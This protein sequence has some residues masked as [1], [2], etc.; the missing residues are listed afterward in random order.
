VLPH[1]YRGITLGLLLV[2]AS[3]VVAHEPPW[4]DLS[5]P[6]VI[7]LEGSFANDRKEAAANGADAVSMR[8]RGRDR[9]FSAVRVRTV[10]SDRG[11]SGRAVLDALAPLQPNL[12]VPGPE[13]LC[14]RLDEAGVGTPIAVEGLLSG[15]RTLLLRDVVVQP[16][17]P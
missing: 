11:P 14:R 1:A 8:V 16:P 9:W 15:S 13:D 5:P 4:V 12:I 6:L 17:A 3:V 2:A 7:R 10:G